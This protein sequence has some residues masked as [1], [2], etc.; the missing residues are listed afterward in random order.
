MEEQ[1]FFLASSGMELF[2]FGFPFGNTV[3]A[4]AWQ[5]AAQ[6]RYGAPPAL[7]LSAAGTATTAVWHSSSLSSSPKFGFTN[8]MEGPCSYSILG[9]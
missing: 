7:A 5:S 3:S 2:L 9:E 4:F 8:G 1:L 6:R